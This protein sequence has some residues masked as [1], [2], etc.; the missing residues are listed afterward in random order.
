[1]GLIKYG[2]VFGAGYALGRPDG[3]RRLMQL[4]GQVA[5]LARHPTA[6]R[7]QERAWDLAGDQALAAKNLL[8]KRSRSTSDTGTEPSD[9][10]PDGPGSTSGSAAPTQAPVEPTGFSG[11]TVAEDSEAVIMGRPPLPRPPITQSEKPSKD[12]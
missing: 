1:M 9:P 11:T 8:D 3:R 12:L 7:L 6:K 4:R 10:Q 5:E 2:V